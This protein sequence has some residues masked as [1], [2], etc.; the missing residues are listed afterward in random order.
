MVLKIGFDYFKFFIIFDNCVWLYV[1]RDVGDKDIILR[2]MKDNQ[3]GIL[4]YL[5]MF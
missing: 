5:Y 2:I 1:Q 3:I 4:I